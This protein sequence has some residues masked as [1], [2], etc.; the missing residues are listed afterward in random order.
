MSKNTV[1]LPTGEV[2]SYDPEQDRW[3]AMDGSVYDRKR[4]HEFYAQ[5]KIVERAEIVERLSQ[6]QDVFLKMVTETEQK[7]AHAWLKERF[8]L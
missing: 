7:A 4:H 8:R 1:T 3:L 6:A 2:G 5:L